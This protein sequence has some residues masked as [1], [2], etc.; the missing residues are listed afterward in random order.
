MFISDHLRH[1][2]IQRA[3][4][5]CEYCGI[6]QVGQEASFHI[7]HAV[8]VRAGGET[9][10]QNLAL[11]CVSCS[12][13]KGAR[14]KAVDPSTGKLTP[15]FNPRRDTW[16]LNFR[17]NDVRVVGLSPIGRATVEA[18]QMNRPIAQAIRQHEKAHGRHPP[19]GHL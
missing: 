6:S 7:D 14:Q 9:T 16:R 19:Y 12:L 11:A 8:P 13:R 17:W 2:V 4:N 15:L 5:R 1:Q 18:L 10:P 3:R